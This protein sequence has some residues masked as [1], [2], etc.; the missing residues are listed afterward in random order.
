MAAAGLLPGNAHR[1]WMPQT[2]STGLPTLIAPVRT[3]SALASAAPDFQLVES[4][5][6]GAGAQTLYLAWYDGG[7]TVRAR[8]F[9]PVLLGGEDPATG[10]AA[11]PLC[12][13]LQARGVTSRVEITQGVEMGRP[14][15]LVAEIDGDRVRV[16]GGVVVVIR[17]EVML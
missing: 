11:G 13:Y 17:G 5:L 4:L 2:V 14:S 8:M 12:A 7:Q 15:T 16:S 1:E 9:S 3:E 10:S 6:A